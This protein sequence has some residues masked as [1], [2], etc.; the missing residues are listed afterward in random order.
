[1]STYVLM[2]PGST[3]T[4]DYRYSL[5]NV[6]DLIDHI[7]TNEQ[8]REMLPIECSLGYG[9]YRDCFQ[10]YYV[11][12]DIKLTWQEVLGHTNIPPSYKPTES[13]WKALHQYTRQQLANVLAGALGR[14]VAA[15]SFVYRIRRNG[16]KAKVFKVI[17]V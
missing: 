14:P 12:A 3:A 6:D 4:A 7:D 9:V 15:N 2:L 8:V 16:P 17:P 11:V 1:M 10:D 5:D 13:D